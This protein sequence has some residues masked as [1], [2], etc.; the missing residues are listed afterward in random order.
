MRAVILAAGLGTRLRPLTNNTPKPM[1]PVGER[2]LLWYHLEH[3]VNHGIKDV[4]INTHY[5]PEQIEDFCAGYQVSRPDVKI[6]TT[7][8]PTLLGSAGTIARGRNWFGTNPFIVTYGD[9]LTNIDYSKLIA[10][11][12]MSENLCTIAC[13]QESKPEEKGIVEFDKNH[14]IKTFIEKPKPG[15]TTS[16]WANAGI[17]I[18]SNEMLGL[19]V[20]MNDDDSLLDFG[21][22]VFP[23]LLEKNYQLG[24]HLMDEILHDIGTQEAYKKAQKIVH[25]LLIP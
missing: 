11:H 4:L 5:L 18:C 15:T 8:E 13:Y 14:R 2:P 21:H 1:L 6:T 16:N 7:F 10:Q 9:N 20:S 19:L 24:V 17:Y 23:T 25:N 3:L 12:K 22:H